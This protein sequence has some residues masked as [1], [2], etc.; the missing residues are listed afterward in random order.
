VQGVGVNGNQPTVQRDPIQPNHNVRVVVVGGHSFIRPDETGLSNRLGLAPRIERRGNDTFNIVR[1]GD[2]EI[3]NVFGPE[4]RLLRRIRRDDRGREFVLF[5][6][7]A[8]A[9]PD[10]YFVNVRAPV[11]HI[12]RRRY[13]VDVPDP[14]PELLYQT[15]EAQPLQAVERAYSL[16]EVRF[17]AP[18]RDYMR[19]VDI[20]TITFPTGVSDITSDQA[21]RLHPIA[22]AMKDIIANSP[23]EVFLI[24]GHTD[25][26]GTEA[27]NLALS[28]RR[29]ESVAVIL[30]ETYQVPPENLVPQG[31]GDQFLKVP[32]QGPNRE[33]RRITVRRVTPLLNGS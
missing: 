32:T 14:T 9:R 31:Y 18:L 5:E 15:L 12:P 3:I 26:V 30:S 11:V 17:N 21:A 7:R 4:G 25:S 22:E 16:D 13:V 29:A 33:N 10:E 20:D 23:N 6:N 2:S 8:P 1:R 27:D 19:R 24:E 28:D